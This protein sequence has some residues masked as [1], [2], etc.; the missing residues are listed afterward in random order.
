[1]DKTLE[2]LEGHLESLQHRDPKRRLGAA[3]AISRLARGD[4]RKPRGDAL[5]APGTLSLLLDATQDTDPRVQEYVINAIGN[6]SQ[7]YKFRKREIRDRLLK[8]FDSSCDDVKI[9][10]AAAIP[11]FGTANVFNTVML[12]LDCKPKRR[13]RHSVA[14][15][16]GRYES[17]IPSA[18]MKSAIADRLMH[19]VT[20]EKDIDTADT[21]MLVIVAL[22]PPNLQEWRDQLPKRFQRLLDN[23]AG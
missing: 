18:R 4:W 10:I 15:A 22:M 20:D 21:M 2:A 8:M 11:Q 17:K 23:H 13:S 1:M 16:I 5:T 9:E 7:R 12:A 3:R 19:V 14:L 6:I